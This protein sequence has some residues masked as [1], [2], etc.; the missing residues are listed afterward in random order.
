MDP[1]RATLSLRWISADMNSS[2]LR[3]STCLTI[4]HRDIPQKYHLI[5][6]PIK[7]VF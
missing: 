3:V 4:E 5:V 7:S 1:T 6:L 2:V